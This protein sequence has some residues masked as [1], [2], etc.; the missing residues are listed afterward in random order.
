MIDYIDISFSPGSVAQ[1]MSKYLH[2]GDV[3]VLGC[4]SLVC[5]GSVRLGL[6]E[7]LRGGV[8]GAIRHVGGIERSVW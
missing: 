5:V 7:V 1:F 8:E 2:S 4:I 6:A 3:G